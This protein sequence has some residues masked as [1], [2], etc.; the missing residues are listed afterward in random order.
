MR[1]T[2][3]R[4]IWPICGDERPICGVGMP[5][6]TTGVARP[7]PGGDKPYGLPACAGTFWA[8]LGDMFCDMFRDIF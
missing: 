1:L 2:L 7:E 8:M 3:G 5:L 6:G 4:A